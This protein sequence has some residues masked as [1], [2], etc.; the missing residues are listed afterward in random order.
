VKILFLGTGAG[1]AF[2]FGDSSSVDGYIPRARELGGKNLRGP[3]SILLEPDIRIDYGEDGALERLGLGERPVQHLVM[4]HGHGD[5][6]Q[7]KGILA[8][9]ARQAGG[10]DVY[11]NNMVIDAIEFAATHE[12]DAGAGRFHSKESDAEVRLHRVL[13]GDTFWVSDAT[14]TA[15]PANH[16]IDKVDM[17]PA[18]RALNYVI[19][20]NGKTLFYG[21]DSSYPLPAAMEALRGYRFD[22]AIFDATFGDMEIDLTGSGHMNFPIVAELV[23]ELRRAGAIDDDTSVLGAHLSLATVEPHDDIAADMAARGLQLPYDGMRLEL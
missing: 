19:E 12:W 3:A 10:I 1:D 7:P 23:A 6:L 9:A 16:F 8:F 22:A 17:I 2:H 21:L 14:F 13:P 5:H 20:R 4:T 18:Q 11:G 15:L